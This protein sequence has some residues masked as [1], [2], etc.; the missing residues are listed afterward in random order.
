MM[1]YTISINLVEK[2]IPKEKK[3]TLKIYLNPNKTYSKNLNTI[4]KLKKLQ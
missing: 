1:H 2:F 3:T 4:Y